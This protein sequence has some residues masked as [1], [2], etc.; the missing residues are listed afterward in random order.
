[1]NIPITKQGML[2]V[3]VTIINGRV[4]SAKIIFLLSIIINNFSTSQRSHDRNWRQCNAELKKNILKLTI[5][6]EGKV[7]QV[8]QISFDFNVAK[9]FFCKQFRF[10]FGLQM[11]LIWDEKNTNI[12][13]KFNK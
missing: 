13:K 1:V 6:R 5:L 11:D 2:H 7:S 12:R 9:K 8:C 3:K 10:I 4:G